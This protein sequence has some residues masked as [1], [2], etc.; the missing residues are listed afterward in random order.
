MGVQGLTI[1]HVKSHLQKYRLAKYIPESM[2]DGGKSDKKKSTDIIPSLDATSGIQITEALRMQMEVQKRLH[3]QLEV[4][5]HLQLRIEAQ[6]KY[7]QKIIE[8]QQRMSGVLASP[9]V[10]TSPGSAGPV[11]REPATKAADSQ[12]DESN[13]ETNPLSTE[14]ALANIAG[15]PVVTV[16]IQGQSHVAPSA[17][18]NLH[19]GSTG[20][21]GLCISASLASGGQPASKRT[22]LDEATVQQ[23]E[24]SAGDMPDELKCQDDTT[25]YHSTVQQEGGN[26]S[27]HGSPQSNVTSTG[28]QQTQISHKSKYGNTFEQQNNYSGQHF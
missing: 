25:I 24:K 6:G 14:S 18:Q 5:R 22:R 9:P 7:L 21:S 20:T 3:E 17:P 28:F 13:S 1:Y 4:Q 27:F 19:V 12:F 16:A 10:A 11:S 2:A 8:E 26:V 23:V 15:V